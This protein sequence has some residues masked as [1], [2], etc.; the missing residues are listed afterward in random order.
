NSNL[1]RIDVCAENVSA[2]QRAGGEGQ[3]AVDGGAV[4]FLHGAVVGREAEHDVA[5]LDAAVCGIDG[6]D[7]ADH[8]VPGF[9]DGRGIAVVWQVMDMADVAAAEGEAQGFDDG[10]ARL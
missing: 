8:F 6:F 7:Q 5:R 10:A 9:A 3:Q 4:V 2:P 1:L